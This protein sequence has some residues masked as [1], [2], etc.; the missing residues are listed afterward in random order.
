MLDRAWRVARLAARRVAGTPRLSG[1]DLDEWAGDLLAHVRP[2]DTVVEVGAGGGAITYP[3][4]RRVGPS[5]RIVVVEPRPDVCKALRA[6]L[7]ANG[8]DNVT[9]VGGDVTVDAVCR[10]HALKPDGLRIGTA[11]PLMT[12]EGAGAI[13]RS[14]SPWL[15]LSLPPSLAM[16]EREALLELL[17]ADGASV[18]SFP[19]DP[20]GAEAL[21]WAQ[22]VSRPRVQ[23]YPEWREGGG[24]EW[25]PAGDHAC[26]LGDQAIG[27]GLLERW[28]GVRL[29]FAEPI[30]VPNAP[31]TRLYVH[32]T[33]HEHYE[34]EKGPHAL[35]EA[36]DLVV[37]FS[38]LHPART[39]RFRPRYKKGDG[40]QYHR[41]RDGALAGTCRLTPD[42][43]L[44]RFPR[45]H[46]RD[47]FEVS[48]RLQRRPPTTRSSST[49]CF[50]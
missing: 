5:G 43:H 1:H 46:L 37:D 8:L 47:I 24:T 42:F 44:D 31:A 18:R 6:G 17:A 10:E 50:S 3:L 36:Q 19:A 27:W 13:R 26:Y 41:Y 35:A 30:A 34:A 39:L 48:G 45:E 40:R 4:A 28:R 12:L 20:L 15:W 25:I 7:L 23:A 29:P 11:A 2:G 32:S 16:P 14:A 22:V 38:R 21:A 49:R 9:V 33:V